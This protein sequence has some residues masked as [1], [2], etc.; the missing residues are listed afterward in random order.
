MEL[1]NI[2]LPKPE[3]KNFSVEKLQQF[4]NKAISGIFGDAEVTCEKYDICESDVVLWM[5]AGDVTVNMQINCPNF[6]NRE[7]EVHHV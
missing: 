2:T 4:L 1:E 5:T 7:M 6:I 3:V